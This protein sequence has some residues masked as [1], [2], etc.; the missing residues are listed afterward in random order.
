MSWLYDWITWWHVALVVPGWLLKTLFH[1]LAHIIALRVTH[2][3]VTDYSLLPLAR[4]DGKWIIGGFVSG[5]SSSKATKT[6]WHST[7]PLVPA[8][9]FGALYAMGGM[10]LWHP[11][12]ILSAW[13]LGDAVY[14]LLGWKFAFSTDGKNLRDYVPWD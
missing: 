4:R 6:R 7:S 11:L 5:R 14:W 9:F 10:L 2:W 1:E 13:S 8:F 3:T 12:W